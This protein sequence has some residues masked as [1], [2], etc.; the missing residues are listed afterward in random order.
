MKFMEKSRAAHLTYMS[1][2]LTLIKPVA[3][4]GIL[5]RILRETEVYRAGS[6]REAS[7]AMVEVFETRKQRGISAA[8]LR[9]KCVKI[10]AQ[11]LD[12][13]IS[14]LRTVQVKCR[15]WKKEIEEKNR[16]EKNNEENENDDKDEK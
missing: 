14:W 3:F 11:D 9:G 16:K 13:F 12:I 2:K 10:S 5:T 4:L 7:E 15:I 6:L 1:N 8:S